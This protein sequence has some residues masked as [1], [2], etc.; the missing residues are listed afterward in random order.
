MAIKGS[1]E[2]KRRGADSREETDVC[3]CQLIPNEELA[4]RLV[5][6]VQVPLQSVE[7]LEERYYVGLV[8][9]LRGSKAAVRR[10]QECA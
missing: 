9:F 10:R 2:Q 7:R 4:S 8:R 3:L 1:S 5:H 6:T